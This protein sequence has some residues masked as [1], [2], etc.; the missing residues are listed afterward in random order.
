[1]HKRMNEHITS[2]W[3]PNE[4][5][6]RNKGG[7]RKAPSVSR[8]ALPS[9]LAPTHKAPI[10]NNSLRSGDSSAKPFLL[11]STCREQCETHALYD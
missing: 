11:F 7:Q 2:H 10:Q 9:L 8:T 6:E 3:P 1:M 5:T 4:E